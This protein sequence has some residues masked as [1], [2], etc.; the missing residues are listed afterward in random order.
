[1]RVLVT[2][3]RNLTHLHR[4]QVREALL[5]VTG[6]S[7]GP[8]VLVHGGARGADTIAAQCARELG[9]DIEEH[10]ADWG[11][12]GK[13]AG[14]IRN[15]EMVDTG[16]DVC[17]AFPLSDSIGTFDCMRRAEKAMVPVMDGWTVT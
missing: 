3:S 7:Y 13:K 10:P 12:H 8:H 15:Q 16:V 6:Y 17:V 5:H 4:R 14:P 1:M 11:R 9:W 2:G